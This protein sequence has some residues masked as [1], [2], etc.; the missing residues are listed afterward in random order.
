MT[1]IAPYPKHLTRLRS[2]HAE[3]FP[4]DI[5]FSMYVDVMVMLTCLVRIKGVDDETH[6]LR[7][8]SLKRKCL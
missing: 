1:D 5:C 4:V 2:I 3:R 7:D 6:Q 8:L